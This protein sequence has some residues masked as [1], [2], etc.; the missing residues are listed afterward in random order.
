MLIQAIR[1]EVAWGGRMLLIGVG[2]DGVMGE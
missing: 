1:R 2:V